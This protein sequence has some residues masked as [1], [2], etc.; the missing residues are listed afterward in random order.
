MKTMR[1]YHDLYC[2]VD[3]LQLSDI[4]E[5]Q[6]ERLMRTHGLDIIHS[7]TLPG[8]S[9]KAALKYTDVVIELIHDREKYDFIQRAKR[10]RISTI[11]KRH[12]KANNPYIGK[13]RGKTPIE[14][15]KQLKQRTCDEVQFSVE[16]A[17]EY[18]PDFFS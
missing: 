3:T 17:C 10:D 12:A 14:I 9:W 15:M 5:Y 16:T 8:F 1:D 7:Y 18:Y 6:R 4:M 11:T 13:V 2:R